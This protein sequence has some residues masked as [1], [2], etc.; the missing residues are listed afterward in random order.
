MMITVLADLAKRAAKLHSLRQRL[1]RNTHSPSR[2]LAALS[3]ML[4][5]A[6]S[7]TPSLS[8]AQT[9]PNKAPGFESL[10]AGSKVLLM[11]VDVELFSLTA[12][13]VLEP[14]ADWTA[15]ANG[16]MR[17]ALR[18]RLAAMQLRTQELSDA[19]ADAHHDAIT[20]HAAV[21]GAVRQHHFG[22]ASLRLPTK[23]GLLD[24]SF[25][26]V[27]KPLATQSG[28][29]FGLFTF[30]RDSYATAERKAM[31][32]GL[33]L[34]GVGI[35]LGVQAGFASLVD[36]ETGQL[37]WAGRLVSTTGDLREKEPAV[38][39]VENLLTNFPTSK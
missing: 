21:A 37:L 29:K 13:G 9:V 10:P 23:A 16:Y 20:L 3:L 36:L 7:I 19:D 18:A 15:Q 4:T 27:F 5:L 33:A 25:G 39:T 11:P 34:L 26:D 28:A 38:K 31:M 6:L 12:G 24:W 1:L 17:E 35:P 32:V 8:S 22:L 30:V 2:A 14:K